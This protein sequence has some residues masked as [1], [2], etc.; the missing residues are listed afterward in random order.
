MYVC[1]MARPCSLRCSRAD[2]EKKKCEQ[3]NQ[4][5]S[6]NQSFKPA[7]LFGDIEMFIYFILFS[8][9]LTDGL[10]GSEQPA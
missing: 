5:Q 9:A 4:A 3:A 1:F 6:E 8:P 7:V 2:R 10:L